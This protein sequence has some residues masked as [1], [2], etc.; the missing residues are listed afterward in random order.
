[1]VR[2]MAATK[3][4][5]R[6]RNGVVEKVPVTRTAPLLA[7]DSK[8]VDYHQRI[9]NTYYELECRGELRE[10]SPSSKQFVRDVHTYAQNPAYWD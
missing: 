3:T 9:I 10:M 7:F 2:N 5:Y 8:G 1:M 4:I 6:E